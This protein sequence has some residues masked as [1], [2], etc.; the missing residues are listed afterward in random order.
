MLP[1]WLKRLLQSLGVNPVRLEWKLRGWRDD[2]R[3]MRAPFVRW[4]QAVGYQHKY[5]SCGLLVDRHTKVCPH[6]GRNVG[7]RLSWQV[8][9]ALGLIVPSAGLGWGVFL[10]AIVTVFLA[11]IRMTQA[12]ILFGVGGDEERWLIDKALTSLGAL[13][14]RHVF[15]GE[16][17]RLLSAALLHGSLIHILFNTIAI[18]QLAPPIEQETRTWPFVVLV[19]VTQLGAAVA[20][21]VYYPLVYA[22]PTYSVGA[23]GVAFGLIGFGLAYTHRQ[24]GASPLRDI[25][26][27]WAIYGLL[28]GIMAGADNAAHVG[29][30]AVGAI[31]GAT[32]PREA[33]GARL[34]TVWALLGAACLAAWAWTVFSMIRSALPL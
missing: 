3:R 26:F 33:G 8:S 4:R 21:L 23:S 14:S 15:A 22:A 25:Y 24:T 18:S 34:A 12:A 16:Y 30:L 28:F 20:S 2:L 6:C 17:W 27:K 5:C 19:T 29:G 1:P 7:S 11:E 32:M 9:R 13:R 31:L 10:L